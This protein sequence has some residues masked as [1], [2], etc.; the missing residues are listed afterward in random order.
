MDEVLKKLQPL[1]VELHSSQKTTG[2]KL[3]K[4]ADGNAAD[5]ETDLEDSFKLV[6]IRNPVL[7]NI[8]QINICLQ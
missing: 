7:F 6:Y 1:W 8:M 3:L 2:D 4:M 5:A